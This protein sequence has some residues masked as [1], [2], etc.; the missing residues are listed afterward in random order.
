[1]RSNVGRATSRRTVAIFAIAAVALV[2]VIA[3]VRMVSPR[4]VAPQPVDVP[5]LAKEAIDAQLAGDRRAARGLPSSAEVTEVRRL[6]AELSMAETGEPEPR[7]RAQARARALRNALGRL[8]SAHGDAGLTSLRAHYAERVSALLEA[9]PSE[10]R[11]QTL[12]GFPDVVRE[13]TDADGNVA[14]P[15]VIRAMFKSRLNVALGLDVDAG[16]SR[17][18][19]EA[20]W[21]WMTFG[22]TRLTPAQRLAFLPK[23]EHARG[24]RLR[25]AQA[26]LLYQAGEF[27]DAA[28]I[29]QALYE[30]T[31]IARMRNH[32]LAAA[33]Q[34][35]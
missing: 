16:L 7:Q 17:V 25:E 1:V 14:G 21:G 12:G 18:E 15:F 2:V 20:V 6:L 3:V 5:A 10:E 30:Q 26:T 8:M 27:A 4:A 24:A 11:R 13:Y 35:E 28:R 9:Q 19:R 33:L 23:Y 31:G 32:A 34:V 22:A 29:F